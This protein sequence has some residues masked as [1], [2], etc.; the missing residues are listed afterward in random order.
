MEHQEYM[1]LLTDIPATCAR[2][3][4]MI[5]LLILKGRGM[6][7]ASMAGFLRPRFKDSSSVL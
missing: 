1:P 3:G 5:R 7:L 2:F 6:E 4:W